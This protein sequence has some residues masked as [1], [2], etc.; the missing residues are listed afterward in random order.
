MLL[1]GTTKTIEV[2]VVVVVGVAE[3]IQ[4]AMVVEVVAEEVVATKMV[5]ANIM[6]NLKTI[7]QGIIIIIEEGMA[8]VVGTV[9]R[10]IVQQFRVVMVQLMLGWRH[11]V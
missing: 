11:D 1:K 2:V 7:I 10:I 3:D 8:G 5:A 9:I 6:T 4:M